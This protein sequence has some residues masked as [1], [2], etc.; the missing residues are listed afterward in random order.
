MGSPRLP[1]EV[2]ER[3]IN[4]SGDHPQTLCSLALTCRQLRPRSRCLMVSRAVFKSR[5]HIFAFVDFLD[6]NPHL[7]PLVHSIVVELMDFPPFPLLHI[8]SNLT[9]IEFN[10]VKEIVALPQPALTCFHRFGANIRSLRLFNLSFVTYLPFSRVLLA[11]PNVVHLTCQNVVIKSVGDQAP[12]DVIRWRL[13]KQMQLKTLV[14]SL[15]NV[16]PV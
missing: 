1:W 16:S 8:L 5:D 12:L 9:E 7:K 13:S 15:P 4:H 3:I 11:L 6:G 14:V 10:S 2:I